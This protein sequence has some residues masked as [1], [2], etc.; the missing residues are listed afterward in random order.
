MN[1]ATFTPEFERLRVE[2][3]DAEPQDMRV[4]GNNIGHGPRWT[5]ARSKPLERRSGENEFRAAI[6]KMAHRALRG[7][8]GRSPQCISPAIDAPAQLHP[9]F[10]G[11]LNAPPRRRSVSR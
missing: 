5:F 3:K 1:E 4:Q 6:L 11:R 10:T 9:D 2:F 7:G 8:R